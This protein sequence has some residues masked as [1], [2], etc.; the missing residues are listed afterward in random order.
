MGLVD[1]KKRPDGLVVFATGHY[2]VTPYTATYKGSAFRTVTQAA[3]EEVAVSTQ[4]RDYTLK[5]RKQELTTMGPLFGVHL[6]MSDR[7]RITA[8][9]GASEISLDEEST[10]AMA[11][12][13][14]LPDSASQVR[15]FAT[16]DINAGLSAV[17]GLDWEPIRYERISVSVGLHVSYLSASGLDGFE[18]TERNVRSGG[19]D[20]RTTEVEQNNTTDV[21]LQLI[22]LQPHLGFEWRPLQ[23]FVSNS[24][25]LFAAVIFSSATFTRQISTI[26]ARD[27]KNILEEDVEFTV[28]PE[29]ILGAYYGWH[30]AIPHFGSLGFE[31]QFGANN[32]AALNYQYQ[33]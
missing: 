30:F 12:G 21:N 15:A 23:S 27:D 9:V 8:G 29:Q 24:F 4:E 2:G 31:L 26:N 13:D 22:T 17:L 14:G 10:G 25:G 18:F 28:M 19:D 3:G 20:V 5:Q 33:F 7:I 6:R 11:G 1:G 16:Y 32:A